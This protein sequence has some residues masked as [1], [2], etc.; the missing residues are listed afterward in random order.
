M[1]LNTRKKITCRSW[2]VILMPDTVIACVNA[3]GNDQPEQL[4]FTNQ[5]GCLIRDIEIPGVMHFEEENDDAEIPVLDTEG[6]GSVKLPG[7]EVAGQ[8]QQTV[9][10]DDLNIP[11]PDP[12]L[13]KIIEELTVS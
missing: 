7:V 10:I 9:E 12:P 5:C 1:A 8:A 6:I 13:I 2:D 3:L 11:Q 4:I